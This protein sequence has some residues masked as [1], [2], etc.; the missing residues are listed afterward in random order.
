[1]IEA[2][3]RASITNRGMVGILTVAL[4]VAGLWAVG[5]MRVDAIP[6]LSD[7]QVIIRTEFPGQAPQL[8]EDQVTYPLTTAMLSVPAAKNVRGFS[9]FGSS[10]IYIIFEDGT[11]IYWA[12]S[13]VLEQLSTVSAILPEGLA[14]ELG[15][16][17]TGVGWVY[18]YLLVTGRSCPDHPDGLWHNPDSDR[19]A[20]NLDA[21][22]TE[23]REAWVHHR[24]FHDIERRYV[25]PET[26][27]SY[28]APDLAPQGSRARL[29]E[30][31]SGHAFD[32]CPL[33]G[34]PLVEPDLSIA[35]LRSI[36]DWY[37]RFELTTVPGVSEVATVG[38]MVRQYQIILDPVALRGFGIGI[39]QIKRAV[40]E[41][42]QDVGG[43]LLER[44]ETEFM[45]R[46][47]GYLGSRGPTVTDTAHST[48]TDPW[49]VTADRVIRDLERVVLRG[50]EAGVP[51]TLGD[52]AEIVIGPEIRRGIAE[53]GGRGETTG[54][55]V[56]MRFGENA[57][58]T[59]QKVRTRLAELETG[60]PPG[61]AIVTTYDRSDLIE[62]AIETLTRTL[63]EEILVVSLVVLLF[64]L[65]AR[66]ALVAVVVLPTGVLGA[67]VLM[68]LFDIHA[69]VMS[70]GGIAIAI[71]VMVDS[72]IIMVENAHKAL[73]QER[74]SIADG[75]PPRGRTAVIAE[76][77]SEVGPSLFFSLLIITVSFV[78][79]F[80]L[81]GQSGRMF[82]PLAYTK[83][84]AMG[85]A[86]I[87]SITLIPAAMVLFVRE[88]I[89]P[90][91]WSR[92]RSTA[93][94]A[95]L[96]TIP[97]TVLLFAPLETLA[98]YRLWLVGGWIVLAS[99]IAVPQRLI[100]EE[101][102]PLSR[103]LQRLYDPVFTFAMRFRILVVLA[104]L[105]LFAATLYPASKI[106]TEFMPP[107]EEGDFLYMPNTDPGLSVTKARE[108]L[109]QTDSLI[110]QFPE[111]KSVF[112]KIGRADTATDPAPLTMIETTIM[113]ERDKAKWRQ[114]DEKRF[115]GLWNRRRPITLEELTD[116]YALPNGAWVTGINGVLAIP[117]LTGAITRGAMPI[118]T[119]IDMLATGI[120][121]PVGIKILGPDLEVLSDL[122]SEI[123]SVLR[124]D[125][126]ISTWTAS[127]AADRAVGGNYVDIAIDRD[128]IARYGLRVAAV[129]DVI[130]TALGGMTIT[131]TVEG[132]ERYPVNLRYARE[133]RE[134]IDGLRE[135]LVQTPS[136]A[137]VPL[138]QLARIE[139]H[140][141]PPMIKSEN[142]R[143]T[144][145]LYVTPH[146]SDVSG[147]VARA[148]QVVERRVTLPP[149]YSML[150]SGQF[151]SIEEANERLKV[152]IPLVGLVIILLLYLA[153]KSWIQTGIVLLAVPFSLIGAIWLV[154]ALDYNFSVAVWVGL[155]ALAGLDAETGLVMLHYLKSSCDR[156]LREGRLRNRDDLWWAIHD[157]AV[158]RIRPKTM[159]V[160]TTFIGLLPLMFA[161]GAG[162][163]TMRRLAAP[164]IGG[165]ATS[166]IAELVLYPVL[167][168]LVMRRMI[169]KA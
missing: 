138:A 49:H 74:Q 17:A 139:E 14:P 36:Q 64:L 157:G 131:R 54:G 126:E 146:V 27:K 8:V 136:G 160:C 114:V 135:V 22:P 72:A 88:R 85:V 11:D 122:T 103:F 44:A 98:P 68:R 69:N 144:S 19:W 12:R 166:F 121:T 101:R 149:G 95:A 79:V 46:G 50:N 40:K 100:R 115:F 18:S 105:A 34:T 20:E 77:A 25:D 45:V 120:K 59:I 39:D 107:L 145:W 117:G 73:E 133:L 37:L 125:P 89:L 71:G 94:I 2:I 6:D 62:R 109:Q 51:V 87:L 111:V 97:A 99:L 31:S 3:I 112:G 53:W 33:D 60:L 150:W 75:A 61:V 156:F 55:I 35:D 123:E 154:H 140:T 65:H 96:I 32:R 152:A 148:K 158:Q 130:M 10:F 41:S 129:Q 161:V 164:M 24:A 78:P 159:T 16:D 23:E 80:V 132:L 119:R 134:D 56:V 29:I 124:T 165:L 169:P 7:V 9:M 116:G 48:A 63:I 86:A 28:A 47:L 167:W 4:V 92:P 21:M 151:E 82:S 104:S 83:S 42:N 108:L 67:L 58:E 5:S 102:N 110:A 155:I 113:L 30:L 118:R 106:G 128:A 153:T 43:R 91:R 168:Y 90:A 13:R 52:V 81:T 57:L 38:G 162:A 142:A 137:Q 76:A 70:L 93:A 26:E 66:S 84:F 143:P 163:D 15:P 127:V 141:G 147:Y 1:M